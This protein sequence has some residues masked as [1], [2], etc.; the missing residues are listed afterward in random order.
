MWQVHEMTA[1]IGK[2]TTAK[3]PPVAPDAR[4]IIGCIWCF[5]NRSQPKVIVDGRWHGGGGARLELCAIGGVHPDMHVADFA[6]RLSPHKLDHAAVIGAG[7]DLGAELGDPLMFA[8]CF[9][10]GLALGK[11]SGERFLTIEMPAAF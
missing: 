2:S 5:R 9:H 3:S 4:Q 8:S 10:H 1:E 11:G 6:Y 7:V